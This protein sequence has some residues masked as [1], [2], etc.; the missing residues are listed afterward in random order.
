MKNYLFT[1]ESVTEGH[2][3]KICD[4]IS[5][6]ILDE[7]LRHDPE[8]RVACETMIT[9]ARVIVSAEITTQAKV[10]YHQIIKNTLKEIGYSK[11]DLG[12]VDFSGSGE[13][14]IFIEYLNA[15]LA[16]LK[17]KLSII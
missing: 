4:K 13:K 1:S 16:L 6:A 11:E 10:D 12:A 2:P 3:D 7:I 14:K 5:D 8:S 9:T 15:Y 17:F